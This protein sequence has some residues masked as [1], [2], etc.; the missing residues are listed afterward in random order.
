[1]WSGE[2]DCS[3]PTGQKHDKHTHTEFFCLIGRADFSFRL[4]NNED[5][6]KSLYKLAGGWVDLI[7]CLLACVD[8]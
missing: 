5:K 4:L 2:P 7:F 8:F 6:Q 3:F 1:V